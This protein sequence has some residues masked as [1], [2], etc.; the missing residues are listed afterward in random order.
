MTVT[1][2]L[3]YL[4]GPKQS[5]GATTVGFPVP[6]TKGEAIQVDGKH[7]YIVESVSWKVDARAATVLQVARLWLP[8]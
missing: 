6:L 7:N 5:S 8:S 2:M 1:V 3:D 4:N